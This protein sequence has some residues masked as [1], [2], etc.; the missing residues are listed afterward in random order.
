MQVIT[1]PPQPPQPGLAGLP[2]LRVAMVT[3]TF[4]PEINGVAM[5]MGRMVG[6]LRARGHQVQLI[7]PR[8]HSAEVAADE[9]GFQEILVSGFPIPRYDSLR[10]GLPA[11]AALA[12][13]W[14]VNRPDVVHVATEGPLGWSAVSV[15]RRLGIAVASDFHTNFHSYSRHYGI[16]WLRRPIEAYLRHFH[17]RAQVTLVPTDE[18]QR[19]LAKAGFR[20]VAVLSRGVDTKLFDPRWRDAALRESWGV[21]PKGRVVLLV[22]RLAPEKNLEL[23][24]VAF[25]AMC[26][27]DPSLRLVLVGDGPQRE[28]LRRRCPGALL[29][30]MR[31]GTELARFYASADLFLFPSLTETFGNVTLEAMASGLAVV[32]FD[33]AAARAHVRDG[34][35]G[36]LVPVADAARFVQRATELVA[37]PEKAVGLGREA[38]ATAQALDWERIHDQFGDLLDG[39]ASNGRRADRP[40]KPDD[41]GGAGLFV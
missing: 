27:V 33:C 6:G 38:R 21:E 7:R 4:P 2:G 9:P 17:N 32:A 23:A 28:T 1:Q 3:E 16:G 39:F 10:M 26:A 40:G 8:Q 13:L 41:S 14:R 15:A 22:G 36:L 25:H 30:G 12:R 5:T 35:N 31:T 18:L 11:G 34:I 20:H 37:T 24:I 19:D 29:A